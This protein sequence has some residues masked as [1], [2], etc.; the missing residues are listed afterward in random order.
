MSDDHPS[1]PQVATV[2]VIVGAVGL[3]AG[4]ALWFTAPKE[5]SV[6]V[7]AGIGNVQI[8]GTF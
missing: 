8:R 7:G 2:G 5:N 6:Q 4:A 3:A 1:L